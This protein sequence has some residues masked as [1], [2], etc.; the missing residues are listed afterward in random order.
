VS[1]SVYVRNRFAWRSYNGN[2]IK[3]AL[4]INPEPSRI[5]FDVIPYLLHVNDPS[6]P[7]YVETG[8]RC[9]GVSLYTPGN[10]A[11]RTLTQRFPRLERHLLLDTSPA[12]DPLIES[13][14]LMGSIGTAAQ[15]RSSDYDYWVVIDETRFAQGALEA[16]RGKLAAIEAWGAEQKVE[17]H[18]FLSDVRRVRDNDFGSTD[19]ESAGSSQTHALKEEFY[20]TAILAAGKD[21]AWWIFPAG[22]SGEQYEAHFHGLIDEGHMDATEIVDLGNVEMISN[23]ELFGALLWQFNKAIESPYKAALKMALLESFINAR[24]GERLLCDVLKRAIHEHP[25]RTDQADPY[26][27]MFD[28]IR[29][30]YL[31]LGRKKAVDCLEKCFFIKSLDRPVKPGGDD[32]SLSYKDRTMQACVRRWQWSGEKLEE[33]NRFREWDYGKVAALGYQIRT[34]MLETYKDLTSGVDREPDNKSVISEKDLTVIG[35]KLFAIY[36]KKNAEKIHHINRVANELKG[37]DAI[38][39]TVEVRRGRAPVWSV[40]R[41]DV[42]SLAAKGGGLDPYLLKKGADP[43]SHIM[44]LV[45][46]EVYCSNTFLSYTPTPELPLALVDLQKLTKQAASFFPPLDLRTLRNEDLLQRALVTKVF[47]ALNV[48]S[49]RW[50]D[51]IDTVHLM[52]MTNW[53]ESFCLVRNAKAGLAKLL[54]TLGRTGRDYSI[55]DNAV[56]DVFVPKGENDAKLLRQLRDYIAKR[57]KRPLSGASP[58]V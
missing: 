54:D 41:G 36:D 58:V 29:R 39:F 20:R 8:A 23:G 53:G 48:L 52:Y 44:W 57:Y 12:R 13:L 21:P 9:C 46:N 27:L 33:M 10:E 30:H 56:F 2:R 17:L 37:V 11:V 32:S 1:R 18:F 6:V 26:L 24:A 15:T 51:E 47:V 38:T 25:D 5:A 43:V 55:S 40:Y 50:K 31:R 42:R 16:L 28:Y 7:G 49:H 4:E 19:K 3:K 34:F 22:L 14:L 45:Q 35:R